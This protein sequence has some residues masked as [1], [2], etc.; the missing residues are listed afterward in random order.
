MKAKDL[1]IAAFAIALVAILAY[2]WFTPSG[3]KPAPALEVT[4]LEGRN[5]SLAS[6]QG[7]PVLVT[8]WATTCPGCVKEMPHLVELYNELGPQGLEIIALAMAYDPEVQVREMVKLK[9]LPYP[10]ALDRDGNAAR[11]FGDVKLTP[12]SFLISPE[13]RIVQQKLGEMDMN[14]L[15]SRIITMLK[16]K[17]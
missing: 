3:L 15:H 12:T 5:I 17:G 1:A 7:R 13:G 9:Q 14:A 6:L 16:Q 8:F 4:T 10:V 11:A 2:V